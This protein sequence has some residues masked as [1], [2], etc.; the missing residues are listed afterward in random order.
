MRIL[1]KIFFVVVILVFEVIMFQISWEFGAGSL[2]LVSA[3]LCIGFVL[4]KITTVVEQPQL[5][6]S[7]EPFRD[8]A[9]NIDK[10]SKSAEEKTSDSENLIPGIDASIF[11]QFRKKFNLK[12]PEITADEDATDE[13]EAASASTPNT[14]SVA[15][16]YEKASVTD[17][18]E[19]FA[20]ELEEVDQVKVTL[21]E[22]AKI[23]QETTFDEEPG[24]PDEMIVEKP[25]T[26]EYV[27]A[28]N[29]K[30]SESGK[31]ENER[32]LGA[33]EEA[34]E[35]LTKKHQ[36]LKRQSEELTTEPLVEEEDDLFAD[37]LIPIPGGEALAEPENE[38]YRDEDIF[39]P[40]LENENLEDEEGLGL[41]LQE[42]APWE[43]KSSE[44]E[45]LLK[46]AT[47]ACE[48]GRYEEAK[49][50]LKSYLDLLKE[51][52]Q[53]PSH[54]VLQLLEK[55]EIPVD[56]TIAEEISDNTVEIEDESADDAETSVQKETEQTDY[57]SVMD[58]IVKTLEK[59]GTYE[60]ALPLLHD[61]LKYNR[62]R[63]NVSAM[64]PL[65]DRIEK[66]HASMNNTKELVETY[67]EHLA[68]K[69]Q[70]DDVEGELRL[71]DLI[72]SHY[73]DSGDQKASDRYHAE[74]LR[75][76]SGLNEA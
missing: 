34:L 32:I 6:L 47:A 39:S 38:E 63:V 71:L 24:E 2:V 43:E 18:P 36:A 62:Q 4:S 52:G 9:K 29:P 72:S 59:K 20:E 21:S 74:S 13:T 50:G 7:S 65:F 19:N 68:I 40:H 8:S 75:V 17:S 58:G 27:K 14:S 1:I 66:A 11:E 67:K 28:E 37:E 16:A 3:A 69:Q 42:T 45:G 41:T 57:A 31:V 44:A 10:V 12:P 22:N 64:D 30:T 61:L 49:A 25:E 51:L 5:A 23:L 15:E 26:S 35:L 54:D 76:R 55:L 33:G 56:S 60:E 70:L 53:K 48:S 73:A 46:I